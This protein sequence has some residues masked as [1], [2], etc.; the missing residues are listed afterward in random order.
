MAKPIQKILDIVKGGSQKY[1]YC[2]TDPPHPFGE[3]RKDR[4]KKYVYLHRAVIENEL[5]RYLKP[6][7]EV[8]H[9]DKDVTNN[10]PS[11]LQLRIVGEHQR[12]HAH[13]GNHFWETSPKNKSKKASA[14]S[15][16]ELYL[17][18]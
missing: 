13:N 7:E 10:D 6:G 3:V 5:G 12:E 14:L 8:D 2:V 18:S 9:K 17:K 1:K 15:V 4:K 11:N 16:V